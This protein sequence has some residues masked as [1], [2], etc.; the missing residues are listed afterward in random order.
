M[1]RRR[2]LRVLAVLYLPLT[3]V[4]VLATGNHYLLDVLAGVA[5]MLAALALVTLV[6][7]WRANAQLAPP[8]GGA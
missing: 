6:A 2:W 4:V 1:T 8:V 7:R 3:T 5:T